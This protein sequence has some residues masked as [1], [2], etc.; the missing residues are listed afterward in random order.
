MATERADNEGRRNAILALAGG[1]AALVGMGLGGEAIREAMDLEGVKTE[2]KE[3]LREL[4]ATLQVVMRDSI[5]ASV[6]ILDQFGISVSVPEY[7]TLINAAVNITKEGDNPFSE[8]FWGRAHERKI[9]DTPKPNSG[10]SQVITR[11]DSIFV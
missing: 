10:I 3:K 11:K 4:D 8:G 6:F 7:K 2:T 9:K 5:D 1:G